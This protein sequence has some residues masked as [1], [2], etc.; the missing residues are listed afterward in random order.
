MRKLQSNVSNLPTVAGLQVTEL[1]KYEL[2]H[3]AFPPLDYYKKKKSVVGRKIAGNWAVW[4]PAHLV[5]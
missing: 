3:Y 4:R 1:R 5:G 2:D